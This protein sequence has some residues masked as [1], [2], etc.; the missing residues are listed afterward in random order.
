MHDAET[1]RPNRKH[2]A[3]AIVAALCL[4]S[5]RT[6]IDRTIETAISERKTPGGVLWV[7]H[8]GESS[9]KAYG[10]RSAV[11]ARERATTDTIYDAASLTKVLATAP[12]IYLLK[13]RGRLRIDDEARTF[14]PALPA[15]ITIRHLL[16]HTSGLPA[17]LDLSTN[18]QGWERGIELAAR[19]EPITKPGFAFRYSD[20][21]FILLGEV[22]RVASGEPLD[23]F[24]ER[25]FYQPLGMTDTGF[26]PPA[27]LIPRIAPTE[28]GLRGVVHDPTARRM[29]GVAGHAGL[30]TTAA[31]VARFARMLLN[32]G[33]LDSTR[34]LESETVSMMTS[35]Q[36]PPGVTVRRAGGWDL[37]SHYSRP[38]GSLFP[39]G[40]YGHTG[41]TG[42]FL[43]IDPQS[44]TFYV[45]LSNRVHPDGKGDVTGLQRSLGTA[46]A[47]SIRDFD[48]GSA[49]DAIAPRA[50]NL[51]LREGDAGTMNGIDVLSVRRFAPL[52]GMRVGLI[53]NQ[54]GIDYYGNP[55]ID[56]LRGAFGVE[57][58]S[59]FSPE[60][61]IRGMLD[62]NVGDEVDAL[63]GLPVHS[64]YGERRQPSAEQ[65]AGLDAL[66]FDVQ[67]IGTRFYTYI[68]TMG[69]AMEAAAAH[70]VK[71]IVLDRVNPI[72]G[73]RVEGPVRSGDEMFTAW[74]PITVRHGMTVGEL[75]KMF[76]E[77]R[78]IPVDLTVIELRKW[79][80]GLWMD[81][82]G[83]RWINP[84]PNMRSL[85][86]ATLYPA[87]GLLEATE[88]SVGRGT[89]TP[90]ELFGA[91][92]I[93]AER[94]AKALG[95]ISGLSVRPVHFT[96]GGS[97]FEGQQC[98]GVRLIVTDRERFRAVEA[99]L[100]FAMTLHRLYPSHFTI[101]KVDRLLRH[102]PTIEAIRAGRSFEEIVAMWRG[103]IA[104][105]EGRREKFLI[106]R[107]EEEGVG[108]TNDK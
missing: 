31:D 94:L 57:L 89:E 46:V 84:S 38:R 21:N 76:R 56:L 39:L 14:V 16:T 54:S 20:V 10:L 92:Y 29:G 4:V 85:A 75:A 83:L 81:Q 107:G 67:D 58:V 66:V 74:H 53:T 9:V 78:K 26:L 40:S 95:G 33:T 90:F 79:K 15:G 7:E 11:P 70:G 43:W 28:G 2:F 68:S 3:A 80:R 103:E 22:V 48:F 13:E 37:E 73:V 17:G 71:F 65:L 18:W 104:A 64:L 61:G 86:A 5:C 88:V 45:F 96:P 93:D 50:G 82:T 77:E 44:R 100:H 59:L 35:V 23:T 6:A 47:E 25:E 62:D 105:F 106:Y 52:R 55:T 108:V 24:V 60:H 36:S 19:I 49:S 63:S 41:W 12:A 69:M 30:F 8:G 42:T 102:P 98:H 51:S 32:G 1:W 101:E 91:P 99:G 27:S 72:T 87:V 34:V 97:V